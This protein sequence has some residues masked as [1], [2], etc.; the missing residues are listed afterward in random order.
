[1]SPPG[2]VSARSG[3]LFQPSSSAYPPGGR[4]SHDLSPFPSRPF[5]P[6]DD[7]FVTRPRSGRNVAGDWA[8]ATA[9]KTRSRRAERCS[10]KQEKDVS[11]PL[12]SGGRASPT[13]IPKDLRTRDFL[14]LHPLL[15]ASKA[16]PRASRPFSGGVAAPASASNVPPEPMSVLFAMSSSDC[17]NECSIRFVTAKR[18]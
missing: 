11:D 14:L 17:T 7:L 16:P 12:R 15:T 1:M 9:R 6:R 2:R 10:E 3:T 18:R 5:R 4:G 8:F 13:F